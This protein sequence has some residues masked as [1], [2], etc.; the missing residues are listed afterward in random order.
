MLNWP[1]PKPELRRAIIESQA[2][3]ACTHE[4]ALMFLL[5]AQMYARK[6]SFNRYSFAEDFIAEATAHLATKVWSKLN[7]EHQPF[8]YC[9]TAIHNCFVAF[10]LKEQKQQRVLDVL[11][12]AAGL[13]ERGWK[14]E[15]T[16]Q[17]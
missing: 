6:P 17:E 15:P 3:G 11:G 1:L 5:M 10:I 12:Q 14:T 13:P 9:T 8:S 7:P 16:C 2:Q 4:L